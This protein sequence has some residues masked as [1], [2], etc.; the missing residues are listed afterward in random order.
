MADDRKPTPNQLSSNLPGPT[1]Y[2]TGHNDSTGKAIIHSK[3][4]V[5]WHQYDEDKLGM[6]VA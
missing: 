3:R 4:P 5:N 6:S 1:V 2:L